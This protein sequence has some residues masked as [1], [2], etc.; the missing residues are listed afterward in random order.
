MGSTVTGLPREPDEIHNIVQCHVLA[1]KFINEFENEKA[2][3]GVP[4]N[5]E[6]TSLHN[7]EVLS[8]AR[9]EQQDGYPIANCAT[10][11]ADN[12]RSPLVSSI[13]LDL[14]G[15]SAGALFEILSENQMS[16]W[17]VYF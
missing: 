17:V 1:A 15:H 3:C 14:M 12:Q 13:R 11:S 2:R 4:S 9:L 6:F 5:N 10:C 7:V 8:V 16:G